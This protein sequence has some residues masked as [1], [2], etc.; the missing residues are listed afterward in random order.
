M[1][2]I[3]FVTE[4]GTDVVMEWLS[5]M[6]DLR[7]RAAIFRRIGRL[8]AGNFGEV[9]SLHHGV[10]ELKVNV[11]PGYRV[12]YA[13]SGLSIVVLLCGGDKSTQDSD[14]VRA[15]SYWELWKINDRK[16]S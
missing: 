16:Q 1:K 8:E 4:S 5:G 13:R 15:V 14:V 9:R 3:T 11:G 7:G 12:Y 6:R 10:W 2:V